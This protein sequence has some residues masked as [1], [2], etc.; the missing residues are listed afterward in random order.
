MRRD[1]MTQI[2]RCTAE[3]TDFKALVALLDADLNDRNGIV[4][5]QY[6]QYNKTD[7]INT[8]VVAYEDGSPAGCGCFKPYDTDTVEIK[9]MFVPHMFRGKGISKAVLAELEKWAHEIGYKKAVLETGMKQH[10]AIGLYTRMGYTKID[11]YGQYA[12]NAFSLCMSK[13]LGGD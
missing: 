2:K 10:E 5:A 9:R 7:N 6:N 11:N 13:N 8:A 3:H 12:G 1:E 4:Q